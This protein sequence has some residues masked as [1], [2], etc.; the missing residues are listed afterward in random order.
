MFSQIKRKDPIT[1]GHL[2]RAWS[3]PRVIGSLGTDVNTRYEQG[4]WEFARGVG[5]T[6]LQKTKQKIFSHLPLVS[7][8]YNIWLNRKI[9]MNLME[10]YL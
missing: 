5:S 7:S 3:C 9:Q 2:E 6:Q 10:L 8:H 4:Q 1:S